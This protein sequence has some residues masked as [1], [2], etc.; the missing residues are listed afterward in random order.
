MNLKFQNIPVSGL[1]DFQVTDGV[2][3][4]FRKRNHIFPLGKR[5]PE[6]DRKAGYHI[7][8]II[9]LPSLDQP[10]D[11]IQSIIKKMRIDLCLQKLQLGVAAGVMTAASVWSLI[12][13]AIDM[14][15]HMGL[16]L[17]HI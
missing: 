9:R 10:D 16:S 4:L 7:Y 11:S 15:S 5:C 13:P 8:S 12:I 14:S 1:L 6:K 3:F 2:T 17:I